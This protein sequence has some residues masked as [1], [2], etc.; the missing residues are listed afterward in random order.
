MPMADGIVQPIQSIKC[1]CPRRQCLTRNSFHAIKNIECIAT[2]VDGQIQWRE[3]GL[4]HPTHCN[5]L[6]QIV[7]VPA[8]KYAAPLLLEA[9]FSAPA[10]AD[11][12]EVCCLDLRSGML[13]QN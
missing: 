12:P 4:D 13:M 8:A 7:L 10:I 9:R 3:K 1:P 11:C 5:V 6:K 2:A